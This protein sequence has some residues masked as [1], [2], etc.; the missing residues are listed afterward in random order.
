MTVSEKAVAK[1]PGAFRTIGEVS[2]D[3]GVPLVLWAGGRQVI[4]VKEEA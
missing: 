2:E 1:A 4:A 3:L